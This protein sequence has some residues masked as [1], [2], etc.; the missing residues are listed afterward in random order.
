MWGEQKLTNICSDLVLVT[1]YKQSL[2][3]SEETRA[4]PKITVLSRNSLFLWRFSLCQVY[5]CLSVSC[6]IIVTAIWFSNPADAAYLDCVALATAPSENCFAFVIVTWSKYDFPCRS[7]EDSQ[8]LK[9][10]ILKNPWQG[11][12]HQAAPHGGKRGNKIITARTE[13]LVKW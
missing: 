4:G 6:G 12:T 5:T 9:Y 7:N 10:F 3:R 8:R 1:R 2:V 11:N 13:Y